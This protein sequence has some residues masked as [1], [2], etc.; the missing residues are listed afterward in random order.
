MEPTKY[1]SEMYEAMIEMM[2]QVKLSL[3]PHTITKDILQYLILIR[4]NMKKLKKI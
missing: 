3:R 1:K 4:I 2:N